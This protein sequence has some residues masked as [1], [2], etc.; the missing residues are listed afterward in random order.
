M[1]SANPD[2]HLTTW[3]Y[4]VFPHHTAAESK[5]WEGVSRGV[6]EILDA[7]RRCIPSNATST[8]IT[9]TERDLSI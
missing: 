8:I 1:P 6:Q 7:M 3:I 2:Q 9:T 5:V 4:N